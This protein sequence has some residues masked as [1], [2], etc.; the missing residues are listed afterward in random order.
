MILLI[1]NFDSFSHNLARYF[2]RLGQRTQV[3]RNDAISINEIR[4]QEPTAIIFSP[5]PCTP[6]EAGIGV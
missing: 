2:V 5:G 4:D 6:A 1:D 3:V